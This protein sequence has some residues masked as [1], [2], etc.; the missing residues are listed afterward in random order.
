MFLQ[1][2]QRTATSF[3]IFWQNIAVNVEK[4]F[5]SEAFQGKKNLFDVIKSK[6]QK[7]KSL[8]NERDKIAFVN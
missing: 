1:F 7:N 3:R 8:K 4:L 6:K 5:S 2:N